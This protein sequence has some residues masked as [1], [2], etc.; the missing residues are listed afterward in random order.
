MPEPP[1]DVWYG[2]LRW[3][4]TTR[5]WMGFLAARP[6]GSLYCRHE[7]TWRRTSPEQAAKDILAALGRWKIRR[8]Q[9]VIGNVELF[10]QDDRGARSDS[11]VFLAAGIPLVEGTRDRVNLW[12]GLRSWLQVRELPDGR[13]APKLYIHPDCKYLLRALPTMVSSKAQPDD[14]AE[15]PD[16]HPVFGLALCLSG[17]PS[18]AKEKKPPPP[19]PNTIAA[20]VTQLRGQPKFARRK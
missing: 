3:A 8:L 6:D 2:G 18:P 7:L 1:V 14:I 19:D 10:P 20:W 13:Q 9:S 12:S 11:E 17:R 5:A 15:S 4:Y 16:E